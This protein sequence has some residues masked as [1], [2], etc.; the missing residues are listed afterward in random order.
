MNKPS[1]QEKLDLIA[2]QIGIYEA[3]QSDTLGVT[4]ESVVACIANILEYG[5]PA[6][7]PD[8]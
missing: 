1:D 4:A 6:G 8:A 5:H 7:E 2:Q 3:S